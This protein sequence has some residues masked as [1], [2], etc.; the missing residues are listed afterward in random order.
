MRLQRPSRYGSGPRGRHPT[1]QTPRRGP[2]P[3]DLYEGA[4]FFGL[5]SRPHRRVLRRRGAILASQ[6]SPIDAVRLRVFGRNPCISCMPSPES[7]FAPESTRR[8]GHPPWATPI[9][10]IP[11]IIHNPRTL[12]WHAALPIGG[13][14]EHPTL[15][16]RRIV[17]IGSTMVEQPYPATWKAGRPGSHRRLS[18]GRFGRPE[19]DRNYVGPMVWTIAQ[20]ADD[21]GDLGSLDSRESPTR[22]RAP[23]AVV[24]HWSPAFPYGRAS[25]SH[26]PAPC[27]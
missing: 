22:R 3:V 6:C 21:S 5:E 8:H 9:P 2:T 14:R 25:G 20:D 7:S 12:R 17:P 16:L 27:T 19:T 1:P 23:S 11:F 18:D 13:R 24:A 26:I 4:S 15:Q 10:P